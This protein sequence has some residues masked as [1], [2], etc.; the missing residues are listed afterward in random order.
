M[1]CVITQYSLNILIIHYCVVCVTTTW[2]Y[3]HKFKFY[4]NYNILFNICC[5]VQNIVKY[6]GKSILVE[7]KTDKY[8]FNFIYMQLD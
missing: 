3:K 6:V 4:E 1:C 8:L 2:S 5:S 7:I